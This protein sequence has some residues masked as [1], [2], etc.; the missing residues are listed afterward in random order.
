MAFS[1]EE[2]VFITENHHMVSDYL[3]MRRLPEDEWYDIVIFRFLRAVRL[4]FERPELH[5]WAFRTIAYQNM[6]S[7]IGNELEKQRRRIQTVSIDAAIPGTDGLTAAD[8]ITSENV[9]YVNYLFPRGRSDEGVEV[10]YDVKLPPKKPYKHGQKSNERITIEAF[11]KETHK[12][13][14]FEYETAAEA[15]KRL[16][17]IN[18]AR[19]QKGKRRF[20]RLTG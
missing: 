13:M 3:K 8:M 7:A 19:R 18:A 14:C 9:N 4:W 17:S 16:S 1:K 15:K 12:N 5:R 10:R 6:R 11:M 20:M 2:C